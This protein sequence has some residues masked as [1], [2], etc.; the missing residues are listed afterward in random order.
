MRMRLGEL[1]LLLLLLLRCLQEGRVCCWW[2]ALLEQG[3]SWPPCRCSRCWSAPHMYVLAPSPLPSCRSIPD[4]DAVKPE[5]WLDDE[6]AEIDDAGG[7]W[8][9]QQ[10]WTWAGG[11]AACA[12]DSSLC[13]L[14]AL[15]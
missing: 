5:G 7:W 15:A 2:R 1:P 4:A 9:V 8:A 13:M 10:W 12:R 6:P 3:S 11:R 14:L